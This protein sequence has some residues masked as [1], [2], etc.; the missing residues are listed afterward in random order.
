MSTTFEFYWFFF[1]T[2]H[3]YDKHI[4]NVRSVQYIFWMLL[5]VGKDLWSKIL[6]HFSQEKLL[7]WLTHFWKSCF[8]LGVLIKFS[9][10]FTN[11]CWFSIKWKNFTQVQFKGLV[12]CFSAKMKWILE[13]LFLIFTIFLGFQMFFHFCW[14]KVCQ[15]NKLQFSG[16]FLNVLTRKIL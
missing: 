12:C 6:K 8:T 3:K 11:L 10:I 5:R 9:F 1:I 15:T 13:R 2:A 14:N 7:W 4:S 16:T